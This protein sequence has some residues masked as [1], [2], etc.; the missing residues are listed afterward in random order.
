M[1]DL[2]NTDCVSACILGCFVAKTTKTFLLVTFLKDCH[3][4]KLSGVSH[5]DLSVALKWRKM[6]FERKKWEKLGEG[7]WGP[8]TRET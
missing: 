6:R 1:E 4:N 2:T 5:A 7:N 8:E 3:E